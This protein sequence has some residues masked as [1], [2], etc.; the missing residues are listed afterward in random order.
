[1]IL[2]TKNA[3]YDYKSGRLFEKDRTSQETREIDQDEVIGFGIF[4]GLSTEERPNI[5]SQELVRGL[6]FFFKKKDS[7][8]PFD[9]LSELLL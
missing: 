4:T 3:V 1:M 7:Q 9:F 5:F 8:Q 6:Q 2:E